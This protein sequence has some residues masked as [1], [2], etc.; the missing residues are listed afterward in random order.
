MQLKKR[1]M[2]RLLGKEVDRT[3]VGSTTTYGMA[4]LIKKCG[5]ARPLADRNGTDFLIPGCGVAPQTPL[6]NI[7][8]LK[9]ARD[10]FY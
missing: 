2:N 4:E 9:K 3:P 10:D 5:A 8:Q 7:R 6:Q 1:V